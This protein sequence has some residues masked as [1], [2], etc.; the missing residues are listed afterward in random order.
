LQ[1]YR[2]PIGLSPCHQHG[3]S[4]QPTSRWGPDYILSPNASIAFGPTD[5]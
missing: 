4:Q 1:Y 2:R 3:F 5:I